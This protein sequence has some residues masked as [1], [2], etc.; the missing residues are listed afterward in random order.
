M[1][2]E[3]ETP[4]VDQEAEVVGAKLPLHFLNSPDRSEDT[5][6]GL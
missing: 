1:T 4:L 3:L 5:R 2:A 6:R